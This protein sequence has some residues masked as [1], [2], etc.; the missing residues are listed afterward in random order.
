MS[1]DERFWPENTIIKA[2]VLDFD[3]TITIKHTRGVVFQPS[4]LEPENIE[5][6]FVDIAFFRRM[7]EGVRKANPS[8]K[9][10]IATFADE[11]EEAL[12][13]GRALVRKYL[14]IAFPNKSTEYFPDEHIQAFNPENQDMD[15]RKVGKVE[16][17]S[18]NDN[19]DDDDG[20]DDGDG[21][22]VPKV[23]GGL[24]REVWDKFLHMDT[25]GGG[26]GA[27]SLQ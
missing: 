13:S 17:A 1:G 20:D 27:C 11:E 21:D 9:L 12:C 19:D 23:K 3:K 2:V 10:C 25:A 15:A 5:R 22:G 16:E 18:S 8:V 26:G 24:G 7:V 14:E 6:N 4:Q